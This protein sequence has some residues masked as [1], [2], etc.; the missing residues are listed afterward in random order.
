ME[1]LYVQEGAA[2]NYF[3]PRSAL[4]PR[5]SRNLQSPHSFPLPRTSIVMQSVPKFPLHHKQ[6]VYPPT[7]PSR[8]SALPVRLNTRWFCSRSA[9][10]L[11]VS[12]NNGFRRR[13]VSGQV[14]ISQCQHRPEYTH[15]QASVVSTSSW[16]SYERQGVMSDTRRHT[17]KHACNLSQQTVGPPGRV[18]RPV[19]GYPERVTDSAFLECLSPESRFGVDMVVR[20]RLSKRQKNVSE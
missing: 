3:V 10:S 6:Q 18:H 15:K 7:H 14:V 4:A 11:P 17:Y 13:R 2:Q 8:N 9:N 1:S 5:C 19:F 16:R 20:N 12:A